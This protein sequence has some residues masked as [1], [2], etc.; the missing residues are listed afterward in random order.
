LVALKAQPSVATLDQP[1]AG[2]WVALKELQTAD[3]MAASKA[4]MTVDLTAAMT[5]AHWAAK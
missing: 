1:K 3:L 5:A 2:K 4:A